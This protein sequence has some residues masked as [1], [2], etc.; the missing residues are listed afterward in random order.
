MG[1]SCRGLRW[2]WPSASRSH[3]SPTDVFGASKWPS[4]G[5]RGRFR[6]RFQCFFF[7]RRVLC[8]GGHFG[9]SGWAVVLYGCLRLR[10]VPWSVKR[11]LL[12]CSVLVLIDTMRSETAF[13]SNASLQLADPCLA[14][15]SRTSTAA[16]P[17]SVVHAGLN[18]PANLPDLST[19]ATVQSLQPWR[20]C[21]C[22]VPRSDT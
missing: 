2:D 17:P 18:V 7:G 3:W 14:H 4:P 13:G 9:W 10:R 12:A 22:V 16:C 15:F 5:F 19:L 8:H 20:G 6:T 11:V 21:V 1:L